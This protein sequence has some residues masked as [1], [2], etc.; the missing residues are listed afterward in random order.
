MIVTCLFL[1]FRLA[2]FLPLFVALPHYADLCNRNSVAASGRQSA[3]K[4]QRS[5]RNAKTTVRLTPA[6]RAATD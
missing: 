2:H 1:R 4:T 6:S 5:F 3:A